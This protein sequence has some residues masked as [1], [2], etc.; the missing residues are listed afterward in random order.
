VHLKQYEN[1]LSDIKSFGPLG[2]H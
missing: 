1:G 2:V